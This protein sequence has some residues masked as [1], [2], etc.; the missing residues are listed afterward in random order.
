M[1][2]FEAPSFSHTGASATSTLPLFP[3][4]SYDPTSTLSPGPHQLLTGP[5]ALQLS[6]QD[7]MS[8][9]GAEEGVQPQC[10]SHGLVVGSQERCGVG[11]VAVTGPGFLVGPSL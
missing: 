3:H 1:R 5:P 11:A 2:P 9:P 8:L 4:L 6:S 10:F 7:V